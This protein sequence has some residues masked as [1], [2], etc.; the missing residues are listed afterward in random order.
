MGWLCSFCLL[1]ILLLLL[2]LYLLLILILLLLLNKSFFWCNLL[3][4]RLWC[5]QV[6]RKEWVDPV[7]RPTLQTES[8]ANLPAKKLQQRQR[9]IAMEQKRAELKK[10]RKK[11][12]PKFYSALEVFPHLKRK[13]Q[14]G[15][16]QEKKF[17]QFLQTRYIVEPMRVRSRWYGEKLSERLYERKV[18]PSARVKSWLCNDNS[19]R[20]CSDHLSLSVYME[21][22]WP[23]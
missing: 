13:A 14:Q 3:T 11:T 22:S 10:G 5:Y 9:E 20:A 23:G 21:K 15:W 12:P 16:V 4:K 18:D 2:L 6:L 19:A 7:V 17:C 8:Q 1:L